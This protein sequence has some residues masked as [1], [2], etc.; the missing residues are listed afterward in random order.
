MLSQQS[1]TKIVRV[2]AINTTTGK[3]TEMQHKVTTT[4]MAADDKRYWRK[5][6]GDI[7]H[8]VTGWVFHDTINSDCL[9][10]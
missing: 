2:I 5:C 8:D 3:D 1:R 6:Y 10:K 9:D 4:K 7:L